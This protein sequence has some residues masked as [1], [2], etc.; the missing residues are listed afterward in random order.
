MF[1][2]LYS[3]TNLLSRATNDLVTLVIANI[4]QGQLVIY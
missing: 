2:L 4:T 1:K 3:D